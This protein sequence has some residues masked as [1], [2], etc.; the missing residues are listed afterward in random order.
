MKKLLSLLLA[1]TMLFAFAAC[2][3]K[4]EEAAK[5]ERKRATAG[6]DTTTST[7][8]PSE[9]VVLDTGLLTPLD[10]TYAK[11]NKADLVYDP[12]VFIELANKTDGKVSIACV[13][14]SITYGTMAADPTDGVADITTAAYPA[15]LQKQLNARFGDKFEVTNYGHAG[16]YI[17][18]FE[19]SNADTLRYCN[20][21]EYLKL[22]KDKPEVVIMMLG[23]NDIGYIN[24]GES[25]AELEKAYNDLIGDIKALKSNPIIFVC[26]PL[27][28]VTAYGSYLAMDALNNAII[29]AAN[30][31]QVYVIDTYN[32]TK[33][34]FE[35]ALYE[36]DGLHPDADGYT[37]L[38]NTIM[39]AVADG[40]TEYKA[41]EVK[42]TNYVVYVDSRKGT[43]DSVGA[44]PDKPTSNLARA[45]DL[46]RGGGT[47]VVSGP[48]NPAKTASNITRVF[49]APE[50]KNK[51]TI[52]SVYGGVDYRAAG[53]GSAKITLSA[54]TYLNGDFEFNNVNIEADASSLK[55]VCNYNNVTFGK[56]VACSVKSGGHSVLIFGHDVVSRWQTEEV[57]SC[58]EDCTLTVNSGTF[59]YLRGGNYRA[60]S[61]DVS[62]YAYGTV[63]S[64]VTTNIVISGGTFERTD[65]GSNYNTSGGTLTSAIGQN[66]MESGATANLTISGGKIAGAVF[67]VPRLNPYPATGTPTIA[68]DINITVN[69]GS[70]GGA[71]ID[72]LQRFKGDK[73]PTV[74]GGY[75]LTIN[76][77][78]FTTASKLSVSAAPCKNATLNLASSCIDIAEWAKDTVSTFKT[79]NK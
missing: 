41:G 45:I 57:L 3:N 59:T 46:C 75:T 74:T 60:V 64:G 12:N 15:K 20:T 76:K 11:S 1:G 35:A 67:A 2:S 36:A 25:C 40:L 69:G 33:E 38:A 44:T 55:M 70:I 68:G 32:I 34:Y 24:N 51:I 72:Y 77:D 48:I 30:S 19:R 27:V 53:N 78:P 54:S 62:P 73:Q 18:D 65:G 6:Q 66:G 23:T 31:Q 10:K 61:S 43:F 14:D 7:K 49:I 13:G 79:V 58:K 39:G 71:G 8:A 4:Q 22:R 29:R 21:A 28:R 63:K 16:A 9:E 56:G 50:N 26:T 17:A 5:K 37:Y 42:D 47:I 52:T